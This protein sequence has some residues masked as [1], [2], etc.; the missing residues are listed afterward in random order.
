MDPAV[1]VLVGGA[2]A[3]MAALFAAPSTGV[4]RMRW[5]RLL[6]LLVG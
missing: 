2:T 6:P 1:L 3:V 5:K 4:E